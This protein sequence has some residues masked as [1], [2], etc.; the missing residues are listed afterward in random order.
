MPVDGE[1]SRS[2][3]AQVLRRL[4]EVTGLSGSSRSD[5]HGNIQEISQTSVTWVT[6]GSRQDWMQFQFLIFQSDVLPAG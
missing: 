1:G 2:A 4:T 6:S 5:V 3:P